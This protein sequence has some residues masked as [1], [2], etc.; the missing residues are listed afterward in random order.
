MKNPFGSAAVIIATAT[1]MLFSP[2]ASLAGTTD[3]TA[4]CVPGGSIQMNIG[5]SFCN[6]KDFGATFA[7]EGAGNFQCPC[8]SVLVS[9]SCYVNTPDA[10]GAQGSDDGTS[11]LGDES[12]VWGCDVGNVS[13]SV[14]GG[15]FR[16]QYAVTLTCQDNSTSELKDVTTLESFPCGP[17]N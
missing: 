10:T 8:G 4:Q 7:Y 6:T 15:Q 1:V 9:V 5:S 3:Q 14:I 12:G 17:W 16:Y 11:D 2:Q 13:N